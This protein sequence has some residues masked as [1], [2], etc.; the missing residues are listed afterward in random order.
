MTEL[1]DELAHA[2]V[3]D[4]RAEALTVPEPLYDHGSSAYPSP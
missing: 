3:E 2:A 4:W 1:A